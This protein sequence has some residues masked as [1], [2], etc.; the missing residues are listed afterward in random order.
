M[1]M[2][3]I[4]IGIIFVLTLSLGLLGLY[5][6]SLYGDYIT[7]KNNAVILEATKIELEQKLEESNEV[8]KEFQK[9]LSNVDRKLASIRLRN[10]KTDNCIIY[11]PAERGFNGTR[12]GKI[13]PNGDGRNA[14]SVDR[15]YD[16]A[17]RCEKS[18]Q[19]VMGLQNFNRVVNQ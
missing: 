3:R 4:F 5:T 11:N 6:K 12:T 7:I 14:L 19:K 16:F 15:L 10:S 8:S 13:I 2:S 18:R 17:G 1:L 9:Q